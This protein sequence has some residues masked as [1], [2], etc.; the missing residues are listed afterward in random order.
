MSWSM[1]LLGIS[2]SHPN[3]SERRSTGF[4]QGFSFLSGL[5]RSPR[6]SLLH[7]CTSRSQ[8]SSVLIWVLLF[9][10]ASAKLWEFLSSTKKEDCCIKVCMYLLETSSLWLGY[11]SMLH[12]GIG[13][14]IFPAI[15]SFERGCVSL[16]VQRGGMR[17]IWSIVQGNWVA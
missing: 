1:V 16:T 17:R 15:P 2:L 9:L 12:V 13:S 3:E 5:S 10:H 7:R 14:R 8:I 11:V 6:V 4:F